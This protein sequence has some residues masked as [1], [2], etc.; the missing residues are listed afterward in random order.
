[1]QEK[2]RKN[3]NKGRWVRRGGRAE[4]VCVNTTR[5][6]HLIYSLLLETP[7][8]QKQEKKIPTHYS[9]ARHGDTHVAG[10]A[11]HPLLREELFSKMEPLP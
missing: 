1:L 9:I 2:R 4:G 8:M 10:Q 5:T 3:R 11:I 7:E 6:K